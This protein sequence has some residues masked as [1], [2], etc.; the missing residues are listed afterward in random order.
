MKP[1]EYSEETLNKRIDMFKI[2]N[3]QGIVSMTVKLPESGVIRVHAPSEKGKSSIFRAFEPL[4]T[5]TFRD[6][7]SLASLVNKNSDTG[8]LLVK[9]LGGTIVGLYLDKTKPSASYYMVKHV[10]QEAYKYPYGDV[11][12]EVL[13][14]LGWYTTGVDKQDYCMNVRLRTPLSIVGTPSR[15]N[16]E[17]FNIALNDVTL[18]ETY[19]KVMEK[20]TSVGKAEIALNSVLSNM[21]YAMNLPV[22]DE[23]A[24]EIE[25]SLLENIQ[26][27]KT[28]LNEVNNVIE[29]I[30][31][32]RGNLPVWEPVPKHVPELLQ[33]MSKLEK[34][35][36]NV[37]KVLSMR[38]VPAKEPKK[39]HL[40]HVKMSMNECFKVE[41]LLNTVKGLRDLRENAPD[42]PMETAKEC[43]ALFK[44][45]VAT[46][47]AVETIQS[48]REMETLKRELNPLRQE[49]I[50][51]SLQM[52]CIDLKDARSTQKILEKIQK[53]R[54]TM[55]CP[56]CKQM[57]IKEEN[58][59][60]ER[61]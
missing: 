24:L 52:I 8:Q 35:Q 14:A 1:L 3:I 11:P 21:Q 60:D 10:G 45:Y 29:D 39:G 58:Y 61:L 25:I 19:I 41:K 4:V 6:K 28:V 36:E 57:Y 22:E 42:K 9:T 23:K 2:D 40:E 34:I 50:G 18:E 13:D 30:Y 55:E 26:Q 56:T 5:K 46:Q 53:E 51:I 16:S 54:A 15:L 20:V 17:I 38:Q 48:L 43:E 31:N 7:A 49:K 44:Q 12:E 27:N 37:E 59:G 32:M 47:D 33:T